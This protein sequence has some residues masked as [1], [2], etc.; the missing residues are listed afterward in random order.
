VVDVVARPDLRRRVRRGTIHDLRCPQCFVGIAR[1]SAPVVLFRENA[2]LKIMTVIPADFDRDEID[3]MMDTLIGMLRAQVGDDWNEEWLRTAAGST[4]SPRAERTFDDDWSDLTLFANDDPLLQGVVSLLG[5]DGAVAWEQAIHDYPDLLDDSAQSFLGHVLEDAEENKPEHVALVRAALEF[6]ERCRTEGREAARAAAPRPRPASGDELDPE[7][8][9]LLEQ[10]LQQTESPDPTSDIA[11]TEQVLSRLDRSEQP[12]LWAMLNQRLGSLWRRQLAAPRQNTIERSIR[13][14][15]EALDA[16]GPDDEP[17]TWAL[18]VAGL[19]QSLQERLGDDRAESYERSIA[20]CEEALARLPE[21]T[22]YA[23]VRAGLHDALGTAFID[24]PLGDRID[25]IERAVREQTAALDDSEKDPTLNASRLN[26]LA[27]AFMLRLRG[28][29]RENITLAIAL[30]E[31]SLKLLAGKETGLDYPL[32]AMNLGVAWLNRD[33]GNQDDIEHAIRWLQEAIDLYTPALAPREHA[34]G[35]MNMATAYA[36]RITGG[37]EENIRRAVELF[38]AAIEDF[39]ALSDR[40]ELARAQRNLATLLSYDAAGTSHYSPRRAAELLD[41]ALDVYTPESDPVECRRAAA[42]LGD[43]RSSEGDAAGAL[44]AYEIGVA[45]AESLYRRAYVP[46]NQRVELAINTELYD[47]C[48]ALCIMSEDRHTRRRGLLHA[49]A[50]RSR[51]F[52]DLM[53]LGDYPAPAGADPDVVEREA[54]LLSEVRET[55]A[56]LSSQGLDPEQERRLAAARDAAR[57]SLLALWQELESLGGAAAEYAAMRRGDPVTWDAIAALLETLGNGTALVSFYVLDD[58]IA[59]FVLRGGWSSPRVHR[60]ALSRRSLVEDFVRNFEIEV[61]QHVEFRDAGGVATN[62]WQSLGASL[63]EPFLDDLEGV[64]LVYFLPHGPLHRLPLHA[65]TV[66]GAPFIARFEVAY[67]PS[68]AILQRTLARRVVP[69][70][71]PEVLVAAYAEADDPA[72]EDFLAEVGEVAT[73]LGAIGRIDADASALAMREDAP[74]AAV[75]HLACHGSFDA[76]DPLA[77]GVRLADGTYTARDFMSLELEADLVVL[78]ACETG[79]LTAARGDEI[80]GLTRALLYAGASSAI[81][82]LWRVYSDATLDWMVD[83]YGRVWG[84][85][86]TKRA[87]ES[88]AFQEATLALMARDPD[89][90]AWAPF[91]LIGDWR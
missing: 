33:P 31:D 70:E 75:I 55:E 72:R 10:L 1:V 8:R 38:H 28:D 69:G 64:R 54:A 7:T 57:V 51:Q 6:V 12:L 85:D 63:M 17:Q 3:S 4:M 29:R 52:L 40:W 34:R 45:A 25:N 9:R 27:R 67:A 11:L 13:A 89:V 36:K 77:S 46:A 48:V 65:L 61:L 56:A 87:E 79:Q 42:Q 50:G 41:R 5:G 37:R 35:V 83:F 82:T 62:R 71:T 14:F 90:V 16:I 59:V 44:E 91:V 32:G 86:G 30:Y 68:A 39:T 60:C 74:G 20:I 21:N 78:S 88:T 73:A 18:A 66:R 19:A 58:E 23:A 49:E 84:A 81:L 47:R 2:E 24:R 80:V 26:N 22:E 43:F 53:G 76:D 15:E